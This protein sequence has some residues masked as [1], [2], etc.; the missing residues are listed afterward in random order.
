MPS[1]RYADHLK[2]RMVLRRIPDGLPEAVY[3]EADAYYR[4]TATGMY[5][6]LKR[7]QFQG[8]TRDI[9]LVYTRSGDEI[10]LVTIHPIREGQAER[11]I[12]MGRWV[13]YDAES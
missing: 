11:R 12:Q 10:R 7:M 3:N 9:A 8:V 6:A 13:S 2:E 5:V 1:F 4:D